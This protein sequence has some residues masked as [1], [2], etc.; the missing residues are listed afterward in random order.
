MLFG[1]RLDQ[2]MMIDALRTNLLNGCTELVDQ[3]LGQEFGDHILESKAPITLF[4]QR[5][6]LQPT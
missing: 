5:T 3:S 1:L 2:C 4:Q 6:T